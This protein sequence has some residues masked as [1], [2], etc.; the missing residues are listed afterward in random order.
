MT[1]SRDSKGLLTQVRVDTDSPLDKII[2]QSNFK[3]IE[4][5]SGYLDEQVYD[6][7]QFGKEPK[8]TCRICLGWDWD[9]DDPMVS[10]CKCIGTVKYIH[11]NCLKE[12]LKSR[13]N[14]R[15]NEYYVSMSWE[16][17]FWELCKTKIPDTIHI[18][19]ESNSMRDSHVTSQEAIKMVHLIE[20]PE[21]IWDCPY[22]MMDCLNV[23][24]FK[25]NT[26]KIVYFIRMWESTVVI[27]RGQ[28]SNVRLADISISR[29]HTNFHLTKNNEIY[30]TDHASKFGTLILQKEPLV[31]NPKSKFK[32]GNYLDFIL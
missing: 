12:L 21:E 11:I 15:K 13:M 22:I 10:P 26:A 7:E 1:P 30:L 19:Y 16:N 20:V 29:Q 32:K 9:R 23:P 2:D 18:K 3:V 27:G 24:M 31:L 6:E 5:G 4:H 25:K 17:V 28:S 8:Y 14:T